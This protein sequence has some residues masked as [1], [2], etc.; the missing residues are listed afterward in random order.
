MSG[1]PIGVTDHEVYNMVHLIIVPRTM[2][3]ISRTTN[4]R[5]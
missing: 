5:A 2:V 1:K 3:G 4:T